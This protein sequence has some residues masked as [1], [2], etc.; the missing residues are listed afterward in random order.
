M[1]LLIWLSIIVVCDIAAYNGYYTMNAADPGV[2][3]MA[4]I[5]AIVS[6]ACFAQDM[7]RA[8]KK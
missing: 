7:I 6:L 5:M 4:M 8:F 2:E 1:R 3:S